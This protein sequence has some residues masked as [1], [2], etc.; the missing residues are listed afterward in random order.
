MNQRTAGV[1]LAV[2]LLIAL[3]IVLLW[4]SQRDKAITPGQVAVPD[5][6]KLEADEAL[7]DF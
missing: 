4:W 2:V 7:A 6:P 5:T 3:G 1:F